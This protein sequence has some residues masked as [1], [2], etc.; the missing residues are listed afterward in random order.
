MYRIES[1]VFH[2]DLSMYRIVVR[3]RIVTR[4]VPPKLTLSLCFLRVS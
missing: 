3:Y 1:S 4:F 2:F